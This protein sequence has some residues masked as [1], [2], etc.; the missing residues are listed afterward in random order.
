MALAAAFFAIRHAPFCLA[1]RKHLAAL[2]LRE[3]FHAFGSPTDESVAGAIV[4]Q[5]SRLSRSVDL[6]PLQRHMRAMGYPR[7]AKEVRS[8][9]QARHG[10]SHFDGQL[11]ARVMAFLAKHGDGGTASSLPVRPPGM[12]MPPGDGAQS[13]DPYDEGANYDPAFDYQ[14]DA[15][16][17]D[18]R[19]DDASRVSGLAASLRPAAAFASSAMR[20]SGLAALLRPAARLDLVSP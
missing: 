20:V 3:F 1:F 19:A 8:S 18:A 4:Q 11:E 7:L 10:L 9:S 13:H 16:P 2:A 15:T 12:W 5:H 6:G 17:G 14:A